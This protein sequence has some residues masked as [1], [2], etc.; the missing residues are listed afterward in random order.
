MSYFNPSHAS[1]VSSEILGV[2]ANDQLDTRPARVP[3]YRAE[4]EA[5][6]GVVRA[7]NHSPDTVLRNLCDAV[8]KLTGADSAGISLAG[9]S[10]G[11]PIF[12]WQATAGLMDKYLGSVVPWDDSPCSTVLKLDSALLM[13]NP[14]RAFQTAGLIEPPLREALLVP[15]HVD[16]QAVGTVWVLSHSVKVF[17]GE[18]AR[19]VSNLAE[20]AALAY[21]VLVKLGDLELLNGSVRLVEERRNQRLTEPAQ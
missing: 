5:T 20:L 9:R 3:D 11:K 6:A 19:I 12:L 7:L 2:L 13:V 18:D 16:G 15:F 21:Q 1:L 4:L 14:A 8:M 10:E 17:D